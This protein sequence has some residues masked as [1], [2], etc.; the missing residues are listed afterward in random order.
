MKRSAD[1]TGK[2]RFVQE[3]YV[4]QVIVTHYDLDTM[5]SLRD[6]LRQRGFICTAYNTL[7]CEGVV[8]ER[9]ELL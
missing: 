8:T 1:A 6:E 5:R 9:E 2:P 7:V 3:A 4:G